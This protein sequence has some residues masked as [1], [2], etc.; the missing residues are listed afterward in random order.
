M[1]FFWFKCDRNFFDSIIGLDWIIITV[2]TDIQP[3]KNPKITFY[4]PV[5]IRL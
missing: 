1:V 4:D 3:E 2:Q 5:I